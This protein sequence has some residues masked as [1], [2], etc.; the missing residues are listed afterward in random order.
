MLLLPF[1]CAWWSACGCDTASQSTPMATTAPATQP[2]PVA[3]PGTAAADTQESPD[4]GPRTNGCRISLIP[5]QP[6]Y[7]LNQPIGLQITLKNEGGTVVREELTNLLFMYHFEIKGPDGKLCPLT[8]E[9]E[10]YRQGF[11][12]SASSPLGPGKSDVTE[13]EKL[14][15]LYDMSRLGEYTVTVRRYVWPPVKKAKPFE[16]ASN[17]VTIILR[18]DDPETSTRPGRR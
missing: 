7:R 18:Q 13:V 14:N 10:L 12:S 17:E 8:R 6:K 11:T 5:T 3:V 1:L 15:L 4:W 2:D 9:G 16:V